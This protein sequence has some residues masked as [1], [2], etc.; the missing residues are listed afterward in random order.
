M[1]FKE[2][3]MQV[4]VTDF[5]THCT[6]YLRSLSKVHDDIIIT[7][8]GQTIAIVKEPL[9]N[10][11]QNPLYGCLKGNLIYMADD[12]DESLGDNDWDAAH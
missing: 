11:G 6:S 12:F 4:T 3:I 5:K 9:D 7:K 8:R 10:K 2:K 1:I